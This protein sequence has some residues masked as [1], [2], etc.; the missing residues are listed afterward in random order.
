LTILSLIVIGAVG[1]ACFAEGVF[2]ALTALFM[3]FLSGSISLAFFEPVARLLGPVI[4]GTIANNYEDGIALCALFCFTYIALR[5]L[6][7]N[8]T[9]RRFEYPM[10]LDQIGGGVVGALTGYL[11]SGFIVVMFQT[12]PWEETFWGFH[13]VYQTEETTQ[14]RKYFPADRVWLSMMHRVTGPGGMLGGSTENQFDPDSSFE[15]R[16]GRHRRLSDEN[17][18]VPFQGEL[19]KLAGQP[20]G[21]DE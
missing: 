1:Y 9:V 10:L 21:E 6:V 5:T 17:T 19:Y 14:G 16:Y 7:N 13:P 18:A 12:L 15:V 4:H 11:V 2:G 20:K 3:V 8:L